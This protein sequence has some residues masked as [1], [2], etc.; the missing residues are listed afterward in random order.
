MSELLLDPSSRVDTSD[1]RF[2]DVLPMADEEHFES[3]EPDELSDGEVYH[4]DALN[5]IDIIGQMPKFAVDLGRRAT[6]L[7]KALEAMSHISQLRGFLKGGDPHDRI[8]VEEKIATLT[9]EMNGAI[10][11][12]SGLNDMVAS[13]EMSRLDANDQLVQIRHGLRTTYSGVKNAKA[14]E[15]YIR[16]LKV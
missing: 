12:M 14:R 16:E 5:T 7:L 3:T 4:R 9:A 11:D 10:L 15:R 8:A 1:E 6:G 13:G 2:G